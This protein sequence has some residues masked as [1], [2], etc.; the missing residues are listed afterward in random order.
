MRKKGQKKKGALTPEAA[1]QKAANLIQEF[2]VCLFL[3]DIV[4]SSNYGKGG[5]KDVYESFD[6]FIAELNSTFA[7]NLPENTLA[8]GSFRV[9]KGFV[10]ALG[11]AAL[12]GIDDSS[13]IP[14]IVAL[15]EEKYPNL[16][17][18]YGVAQDGWSEGIELIK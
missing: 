7:A 15:K 2:G 12:G 3:L 4:E 16:R 10:N 9:E 6:R 17:L 13:L 1:E 14:K 8:V 11:D 18:Y 5:D